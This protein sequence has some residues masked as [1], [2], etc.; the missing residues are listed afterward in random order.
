MPPSFFHEG[1]LKLSTQSQPEG[2]Q[3][4]GGHADRPNHFVLQDV[5]GLQ[6]TRI[7]RCH[8]GLNRGLGHFQTDQMV[9]NQCTPD[10]MRNSYRMLSED[11]LL[12]GGVPTTGLSI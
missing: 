2:G 5:Q 9:G 12:I 8:L 3:P 7:G 10:L 4:A 1:E 11:R 6:Q